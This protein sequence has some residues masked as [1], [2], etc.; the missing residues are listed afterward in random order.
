MCVKE[1]PPSH[2]CARTTRET[3]AARPRSCPASPRIARGP[4]ALAPFRRAA[5]SLSGF[6]GTS[7]HRARVNP[8]AA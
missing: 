4:P 1:R 6:S 7:H 2:A 8:G 5:I 3:A